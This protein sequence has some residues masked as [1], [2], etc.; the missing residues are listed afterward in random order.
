MIS[1]IYKLIDGS[2]VQKHRFDNISNNLANVN[3]NAFKKDIISFNQI[4]SLKSTSAIDFTPGPLSYTGNKLD[5]A[6]D[7][8]GF[9][10][11][12]TSRGIRYT[13]D[14]SFILN[15]DKFLVTQNGD[16]VLGQNGP[17][18]INGSEVQIDIDGQVVVENET[19]DKILVVDFE[20]PRFLRKEGSSYYMYEGKEEDILTAESAR[21][22]QGYIE[23]SN[24][25]PIE[26]MIK[27]VETLRAF[28]SDQ[29]AIQC[30]DEM[31]SRIVN[32]VGLIQ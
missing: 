30:M 8:P 18:K 10:K 4:L 28:E 7:V 3:T 24:V 6:L 29:K 26:E 11:I 27:M 23:R 9:F 17:I 31:N 15:V 21:V 19:V 13:R 25:N 2:L 22:R 14:G 5:I 20:E 12:Q 1:G 16:T 32:D